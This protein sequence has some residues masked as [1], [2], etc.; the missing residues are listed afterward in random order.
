MKRKAYVGQYSRKYNKRRRITGTFVPTAVVPPRRLGYTTVARTR[1]VYAAG[2]MKYFDTTH[3]FT[4]DA[5]TTTWVAG[6]FASPSP[7]NT[8]VAPTVGAAINQRIGRHIN[9][10]KIK[11]KG[12]FIVAPQAA[13]DDPCTCRVLL[14]QDLQTNSSAM[15]GAQLLADTPSAATTINTFQNLDNFGRFRVLKDKMVVFSNPNISEDAG[16]NFQQSGMKKLFKMNI[17][18]KK[19]VP[20]RFNATN[21]GTVADI[22]DNS[23]HLIIGCDNATMGPTCSYVAR[24]CYKE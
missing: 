13:V 6:T 10:L 17:K 19:P 18:F 22:V 3:G 2:E 20:I 11:I 1:G 5:V 4:L 14:V 8:L 21:G 23:F 24:V 15:T 16:G 12:Q 7:Q 9:V